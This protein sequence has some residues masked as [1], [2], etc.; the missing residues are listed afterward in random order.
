MCRRASTIVEQAKH[1]S[2]AQKLQIFPAVKELIAP[3][4]LAGCMILH[5]I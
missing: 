2:V 4:Q 3:G 5:A 1:L